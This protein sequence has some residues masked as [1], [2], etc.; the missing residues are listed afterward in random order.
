MNCCAPASRAI[1]AHFNTAV[2][3]GD[4]RRYQASGP[5][6]RARKLIDALERVGVRDRTILD[7]GAG[8]GVISLELLKRG[9]ASATLADASTSYL[10]AARAE[11]QALGL[12]DR[13]QFVEGDFVDTSTSLQDADIVV[14]DRSVCCYPDWR[15]LLAAAA[16]H[17][18]QVLA[19]TYPR[20]RLGVRA[21]IGLENL[22]RRWAKNEFRTFVHP[23]EQLVS[24][25]EALGFRR[26]D[27]V[28]MFVWMIEVYGRGE[29]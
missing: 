17:A 2:A 8:I 11:G 27:R 12:T 21:V 6:K 13:L 29:V 4:R 15:P 14:M 9:A 25:L 19:L 24:A 23:P 5:E 18:R 3:E 1:S 28:Q 7:V 26:V 16:R 20:D 10:T 22:R